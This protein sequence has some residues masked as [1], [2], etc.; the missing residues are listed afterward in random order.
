MISRR[1]FIALAAVAPLYV[2][3]CLRPGAA[4]RGVVVN[5]VHSQLNPTRVDRVVRVDSL[6]SVQEAIQRAARKDQVICI[7]GGRHAMGA[8]QFATDA[9]LLDT[10]Q[11]NRVLRF[12]PI[13]GRIEVQAGIQWPKLMADL[14]QEQDGYERMWGIAQK[15]TG[16]DRL[17]LGGALAANAHG[18]GLNMKP[19]IADVESF[20]LVDAQGAL[21]TCSRTENEELFRLAI[22]GYGLFGFVY[23]VTLRLVPKQK[24]QR[25]VELSRVDDLMPEIE[26]R[27]ANGHLYGDFQ[28]SVTPDDKDYLNKGILATY[29]PVPIDTPI[30]AEQKKLTLHKWKRL[31]YLAHANPE[32]VFNEYADHY[33]STHEQ[34]YWSD[35]HQSSSYVNNYHA[36][37][38][39]KLGYAAKAT[40]VITEVYVP[41]DA[42]AGFMKAAA[43]AFRKH[44]VQVIYGTIRM[45]QPDPESFLAWATRPWACIIFNLH[46]P[47]TQTGKKRSAAA[48][49]GL[50]DLAIARGGRYYLTY[51]T[52]ATRTQVQTC[53]PQ[54]P[55]FLRLKKRYDPAERFQSNWY[56]H[57]KKMFA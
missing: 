28:F 57:Y 46:T 54:L 2:S 49:R 30:P 44:E 39:R 34:I 40:E 50:I 41:R 6:S 38:D 31:V 43:E 15:Q 13:A 8:Q 18:R 35:A 45:I 23:S 19:I 10:T 47:H 29:R 17:S 27:T 33:L 21:K 16:A 1:E 36:E 48:F 7:A 4:P 51:H 32:Q 55:Q 42:L 11:L 37:I 52:H 3:G 5:D 53:Y 25:L 26:K 14:A 9:V 24:V 56:R 20:T 12:D 22:G